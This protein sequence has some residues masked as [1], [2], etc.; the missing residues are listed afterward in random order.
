MSSQEFINLL[1]ARRA[2]IRGERRSRL[3]TIV[4]LNETITDSVIDFGRVRVKLINHL[5]RLENKESS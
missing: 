3:K 2:E 5:I 4:Q 1:K